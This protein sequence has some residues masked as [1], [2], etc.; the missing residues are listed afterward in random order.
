MQLTEHFSLDEFTASDTAD[1][2]GIDNTPL[3]EHL[4]HL[5]ALAAAMEQVRALFDRAINITSAYRS[6]ALNAA[7]GGVAT[8]DHPLGFA[9]DFH[10]AGFSDFEAAKKIRDSSLTFDQLIWERNRC[11]HFSINPRMR[12]QVLS[13]HGGPGT[14]VTPGIG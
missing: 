13:Q 4:D 1:E 8:S 14:Q 12:R 11:V 10:V 7:V 6:P 3:P 5:K 9:C 2:K